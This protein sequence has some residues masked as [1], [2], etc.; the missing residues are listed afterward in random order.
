MS[1]TD[2]SEKIPRL[3]IPEALSSLMRACKAME[4][5]IRLALADMPKRKGFRT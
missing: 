5:L 3:R 1:D 2:G 4:E